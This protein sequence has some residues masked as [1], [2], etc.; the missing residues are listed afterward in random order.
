MLKVI[1]LFSG[2]GSQAKALERLYKDRGLEF[3]IVGTSD[4][5]K[6]AIVSY[7]TIHNGLTKEMIDDYTF[8]KD[9]QSMADFLKM[10]NIGY[11]FQKDKPYN[12]D[13]LVSSKEKYLEK[14]YLATILSKQLGDI[15]KI[16]SLPDCDL[17]IYSFPC[18]DI[19]TAGLQKGF[20]AEDNTRS[21]LVWQV[22]RLLNN[23]IE[24]EKPLPKYLLM[25]NVRNLVSNTFINDFNLWIGKLAEIGYVT[26]YAV[27]NS[28]DFGVPQNRERV[29]AISILN[30]NNGYEFPKPFKLDKV[31]K[32]LLETD[33]DEKYFISLKG[34]EYI[35][36][37]KRLGKYTNVNSDVSMPCTAVGQNNWTGTFIAEE[38][39]NCVEAGVLKGGKWDNLHEQ[40]C[41]VYNTN[42]LSPALNTC[43]GG[44]H[45]TKIVC[46]YN[47]E[48]DGTSRT[49]KAQYNNN[50][51][52][53]FIRDDSFGA[54]GVIEIQG[55]KYRIRKLTP[56]ECIRLMDF[57]DEDFYKIKEIGMSDSQIYKQCGNSIVVSCLYHIFRKLFVD[58]EK[59]Q[60]TFFDEF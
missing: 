14:Y 34:V 31:L 57:D 7:A 5:D 18:T 16:S 28:K 9:R 24:N 6:D 40:S 12:W 11:D 50:N 37:P 55:I 47:T 53:N 10:L 42:A 3:E 20:K 60:I 51:M 46:P 35:L 59:E 58:T 8:P 26:Y 33:V 39:E 56:L 23:K 2:I 54:T 21:G 25:E 48:T 15:S 17:L 44:G 1:E 29:F 13:R 22:L 32:D 49:I 19:S 45:E 43:E 27:L 4:I 36:N 30:D 38:Y 41:R 52:R